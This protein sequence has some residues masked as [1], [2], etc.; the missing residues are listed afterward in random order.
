MAITENNI[1]L[2]LYADATFEIR[3][4]DGNDVPAFTLRFN[5]DADVRVSVADDRIS[6]KITGFNYDAAVKSSSI[7]K[8]DISLLSM[9]KFII[10]KSVVNAANPKLQRGFVLPKIDN[11]ALR[12]MEVKLHD[13]AIRIGTDAEFSW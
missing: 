2:Y 5:M 1:R 4:Q 7:G 10:E 8:I 13:K 6:A 3:Q 11:C 12:N 9:M